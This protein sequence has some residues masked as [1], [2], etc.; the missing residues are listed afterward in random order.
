MKRKLPK[1]GGGY[2]RD[3]KTGELISRDSAHAER[4][5]NPK[6][7]DKPAAQSAKE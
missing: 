4:L 6:S 1:R 7:D 3:P 5:L 2:I